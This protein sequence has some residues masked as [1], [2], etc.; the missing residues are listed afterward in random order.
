MDKGIVIVGVTIVVILI[1]VGVVYFLKDK[2]ELQEEVPVEQDLEPT[3]VEQPPVAQEQFPNEEESIP[4]DWVQVP[5]VKPPQTVE[6]E[7]WPIAIDG[8]S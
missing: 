2:S 6:H 3:A 8:K 5:T 1:I 4:V 7:R